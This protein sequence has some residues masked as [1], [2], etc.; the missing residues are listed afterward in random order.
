MHH[1]A[2]TSD[3][4]PTAKPKQSAQP[5]G[6]GKQK[7]KEPPRSKEVQRLEQLRDGIRYATGRERDPKG[8]CFCQARMHLL[9]SHTPICRNCGLILC[10]L[11]LPRYACPHCVSP[12]LTPEARNTLE[13][14]LDT[15]I[16]ETIAREEEERQRAIEEARA[17][18]GAFPTL[19]AS[20]PGLP[21]MSDT[22]A[23]HPANQTHKVLSL[24]SKTKKHTISS[25]HV[26]PAA[27]R[28]ASHE[29]KSKDE[30]KADS[31]RVP[32]P[33]AEVPFATE[34]RDPGRPW[35]N[36]KGGMVTYVPVQKTGVGDPS[37]QRRK[38]GT[39]KDR[40]RNTEKEHEP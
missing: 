26:S 33:P 36:L 27:S 34:R 2:W 21:S 14:R 8:G 12:L 18:A 6:K 39:G 24:D 3:R 5:Q 35:A 1:T 13:V 10:E 29:R 38:K 9:S 15:Q 25:Y 4:I 16:T 20:A 22:L 40:S 19:S 32:P 7:A 31:K 17:A 28:S 37:G 23:T 30:V 11:Q